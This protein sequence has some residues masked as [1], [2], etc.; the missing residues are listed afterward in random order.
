MNRPH[1][2][3]MSVREKL[4][5]ILMLSQEAL[6]SKTIE[7]KKELRTMEEI[8]EIMEKYQY[9]SL[10][11][12]GGDVV[13]MDEEDPN[14]IISS[15]RCR[16]EQ[17]RKWLDALQ[18][19]VR[20]P[21]LIAMDSESGLGYRFEDASQAVGPL[22]VGAADD[23][24]LTEELYAGIAREHRAV[25]SNWRWAPV[26]DIPNRFSSV[27]VGRSFSDDVELM[28]RHVRAAIRGIE[29]E[30]VATT[31]KHFPGADP[32]EFRD[33]HLI[34]PTINLSLEDWE[35]EQGRAF[36][37]AI[38]EGVMTIMTAHMAFPAVD[39]EK[40]NGRYIPA[41]LSEKVIEGL[42]RKKMGF[43]GVI[44]TDDVNMAG[45]TTYCSREEMLVRLINAGHD[46]LLGVQVP[47]LDLVYQAVCDGRISMERIDASC[48][49]VLALKE[50]IGLF[51]GPQETVS[52]TEA[53]RMVT[54]ANRKIA[55]KGITLLRDRSGL[56][57]ISKEAV[58]KVAVVGIAHTPE[59]M[60]QLEA[61]KAAFEERGAWVSL[62]EGINAEQY[63]QMVGEHDLI[64]YCGHISQH[65]PMGMPSFYDEKMM[66]FW[67]AFT[68]DNHKA[69]GVSTGYP[70]LHY[71]SMA[72]A[73]A[74]VNLYSYNAETLTA[75]V[76]AIYGEIP[77]CGKSPV[78]IEPKLRYIYC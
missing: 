52:M 31:V 57:P 34:T 68:K 5:Q 54:A 50:R 23:E 38:D 3:E 29:K 4:A 40:I 18:K 39:D 78:D 61:M 51:D 32:Y 66:C 7:G 46:V 36:Q 41:S 48:E 8:A 17:Y 24:Q 64:I 53:N 6:K 70:Y 67:H 71:D 26:V 42:L 33:A 73:N 20:L 62:Y 25:G 11:A 56:L 63:D 65:R 21:M 74:F 45:L 27:S 43:E 55:E 14:Q 28:N 16:S 60:T 59:L 77:F 76:A 30:K 37:N 2:N 10:Y 47:D 69:I 1:V 44:I 15:T 9:G 19:K 35:R 72:A 22:A 49:R 75:F 58:K 13:R 12:A